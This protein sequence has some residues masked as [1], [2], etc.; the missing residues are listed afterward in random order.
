MPVPPV[1]AAP[2]ARVALLGGFGNLGVVM[3]RLIPPIRELPPCHLPRSL[4]SSR[5][6]RGGPGSGDLGSAGGLC[7]VAL[8]CTGSGS[9]PGCALRAHLFAACPSSPSQA[10]TGA[11]YAVAPEKCRER[12]TSSW[13]SHIGGSN[14]RTIQAAAKV[15]RLAKATRLPRPAPTSRRHSKLS[16]SAP[17]PTKCSDG[18]AARSTLPNS[19]SRLGRLR[20]LS[21]DEVCQILAAHG[22]ERFASAEVTS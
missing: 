8:W 5:S 1:P 20:V 6:T 22:F 9:A 2:L 12:V 19:S 14:H 11:S 4:T 16:S 15:R 10:R 18:C 21:G 7:G 13:V 3:D 17:H